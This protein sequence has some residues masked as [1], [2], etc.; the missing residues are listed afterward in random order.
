MGDLLKIEL[1]RA[2]LN[3]KFYVVVLFSTIIAIA[4]FFSTNGF[5]LAKNW[6]MYMRGDETSRYIIEKCNYSDI[7]LEIWMPNYGVSSRFYFLLVIILPLLCIIPYG[8]SYIDE[9]NNGLIN[10]YIIRVGKTKYY[11]SK[12]VSLFIVG[13]SISIIPLLVNLIICCMAL[14]FGVP[15][16]STHFFPVL[17]D[18]AFSKLYYQNII[19]Y[20]LLYFIIHFIVYGLITC[21]VLSFS[22]FEENRYMLLLIPFIFYFS[23]HVFIAYG[24]NNSNASIMKASNIMRLSKDNLFFFAL[25][26]FILLFFDLMYFIRIRKDV[27]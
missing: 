3:V 21:I 4:S 6:L 27:I 13:G 8:T 7:A 23:E 14:P 26:L 1:Q 24:L 5:T 12:F 25:Q 11:I 15:M 9:K 17:E 18:I 10:Q 20:L 22:Y 2:F 16:R 19:L